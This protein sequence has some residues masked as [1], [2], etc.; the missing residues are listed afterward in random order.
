MVWLIHQKFTISWNFN[1]NCAKIIK[2]MFVQNSW[3]SKCKIGTKI[4]IC[5]FYINDAS[6]PT[7]DV[8]MWN[9]YDLHFN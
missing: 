2:N 6:F 1:K 4:Y 3:A 7:C 8:L 9:M 5:Y